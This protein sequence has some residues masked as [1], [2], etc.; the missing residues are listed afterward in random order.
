MK[1]YK[2]LITEHDTG[3]DAALSDVAEGIQEIID[4]IQ[5]EKARV[6]RERFEK[7]EQ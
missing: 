5:L 3:L 1:I 2:P 7:I 6:N 4:Q